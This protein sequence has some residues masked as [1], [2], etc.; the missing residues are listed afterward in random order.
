MDEWEEFFNPKIHGLLRSIMDTIDNS[1]QDILPDR[2]KVL[3]I[4]C[5]VPPSNIKMVMIAQSPYPSADDACGI[6]FISKIG[7]VPKSLGVI[8]REVE[9]EYKTRVRDPN[10]MI[11]SWIS[12]GAFI[13]NSSPTLGIN[14]PD[15]HSYLGDHSVVWREFM[16]H[17]LPFLTGDPDIPVI[18]MG[19]V[20]WELET[21]TKH[22]K[23]V[24]KTPHPVSRG[25]KQFIGCGVF[26]K[27]DKYFES[28]GRQSLEWI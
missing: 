20:A 7:R 1:G 4:F 5:R 19:S 2:D 3:E 11:L 22:S 13:I 26:S 24:I 28:I 15:K 21:F 17:L 8:T 6:P 9:L 12:K 18:L 14:I 27:I 25:D 16:S 10:S 23:C